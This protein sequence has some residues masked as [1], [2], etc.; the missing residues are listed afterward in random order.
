MKDDNWQKVLRDPSLLRD[1][2]REHLEQE[3]SYVKTIL[4][5]TEALQKTIQNEMIGRLQQDE[6]GVPS[7]DGP[8]AYFRRYEEGNEHP[9]F[10]RITR[11]DFEGG[12]WAQDKPLP[13]SHELL[14]DANALAANTTFFSL[15]GVQHAPSHALLAYATDTKGSE[16]YTIEILDLAGGKLLP[17]S[18]VN[19]SGS[20]VWASESR[21]ILYT[22]LDESH[23]EK[24]IYRHRLGTKQEEDTL[25]YEEADDGFFI[26][27]GLTDSHRFITIESNDHCTSEVRL[28]PADKPDTPPLLI[29]AREEGVQYDVQ[30]VGEAL[31]VL[32][33]R[34][35]A[36]DFKVMAAPLSAPGAENWKDLVP[37]QPGVLIKAITVIEGFFV[38]SERVNAL[39]RLVVSAC[40]ASSSGA[41]SLHDEHVIDF[42]EKAFALNLKMGSEYKTSSIRFVFSSPTTPESTFDYNIPTR[43]RVLRKVQKVP[44]GHASG[45]YRCTRETVLTDDGARVPITILY[46]KDTVLD[47]TAPLLL[48]GYGSYGASLP[49]SFSTTRLSLVDRGVV[50][51]IAHVRGGTDCGYGWYD[52]A[53][54]TMQKKNTFKDFLAAADYL[55]DKKFTGKGRIS[56]LGRSAGG[57]LVGSAMNMADPSLFAA[58]VGEVP[59]VDVLNTMCDTSLPLTPPEWPEWGNPIE[60]KEAYD[61]IESYAPYEQLSKRPYPHVLATAGLTDPRVTYWEP[62]KWIAKL[63]KV[64][65]DDGGLS[66]LKTDMGAGHAGKSGRFVQLE[67]E[68]FIQAFLLYTFYKTGSLPSLD[69]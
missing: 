29:Q 10:C 18:L 8:Y 25:V 46:H 63:R 37:H 40:D 41:V 21:D 3:N 36:T 43:E 20:F 57:M 64:R 30:D 62:A 23:R 56:I 48:Y 17:D 49:A 15:G 35:G 42:D 31:L 24:W 67:D 44:S 16:Y 19:C 4:E 38:R 14:L 55:V 54:K 45:D 9:H 11:G 39:P 33:N 28:I 1:D 69:L 7:L 53:G 34:D 47:G 12:V 65:T 59:F 2:I 26:G 50:Y 60:S 13:P 32:T 61:Y 5:P 58:V 22:K 66:L 51:A 68:S 52:P 27:V 6:S